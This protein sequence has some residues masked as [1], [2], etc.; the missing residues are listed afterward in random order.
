MYELNELKH[1]RMKLNLTQG[2]LAKRCG[3]SQSLIAKIESGK[4]DPGYSSVKKI[5]ETLSLLDK[6]TEV[7]AKDIMHR[8]IL[9]AS[10]KD[11]LKDTITLMRQKNISQMPVIDNK[12][13]VGYISESLLLEKLLDG[14][15]QNLQVSEI[16]QENPPIIPPNTSQGV[17]ANLLQHFPFVLVE[18]KGE[19][20]GIVTKADLLAAMYR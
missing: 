8:K 2:E 7:K 1:I 18:E 11:T 14:N 5:F 9:S 16:M 12:K 6:N 13:I 17:V 20:K 10:S 3:V 15:A 4:I 19:L